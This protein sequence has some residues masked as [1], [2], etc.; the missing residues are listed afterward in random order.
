M[1]VIMLNTATGAMMTLSDYFDSCFKSLFED[2]EDVTESMAED[3]ITYDSDFVL[4]YEDGT[5]ISAEE[6][7]KYAD[8]YTAEYNK[9]M[10]K[11]RSKI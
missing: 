1:E 5:K 4:A 11:V 8:L 3:W 6:S 7:C 9:Y 10:E 2:N